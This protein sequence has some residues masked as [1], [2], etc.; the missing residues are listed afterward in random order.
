MQY[1]VCLFFPRSAET[2]NG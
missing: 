2:D 1:F